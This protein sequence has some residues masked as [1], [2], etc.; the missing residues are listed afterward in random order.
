MKR[1]LPL[2]LVVLTVALFLG[3]VFI[4]SVHIPF[5]ETLH[6]LLGGAASK[7]SWAFIIVHSRIPAAVVALLTGAALAASGLMLQTAF[8]NPLAGPDILGINSGAGLGV[9]IVMLAFGGSLPVGGALLGAQV[10]VVAAA[11]IGALL[12][13]ALLLVFSSMTRSHV[14][15]LIIGLMLS[16][17]VSSAITLLNFFSTAEGVQS[18]TLWGMGSFGGVS[19]DRLPLFALLMAVGLA[20]AIS[21]I[22]PL[23]ALLLGIHY[24]E[25]LGINIRRTRALLLLSTGLLT[26]VSTAYCGPVTFIG[27]AVPHMARL[28]TGTAN[29]RQLM[30]ATLLCGSVV[31]LLCNLLTTL[32]A[33]GRLLPLGAITPLIGAPVILFVILKKK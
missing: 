11:F 6:V 8:N 13:T 27:L 14:M 3:N 28:L 26:A 20:M 33:G 19:L 16:Y 9:A 29:H 22:K 32:P 2:L 12:V 25:N 5:D 15:L 17:M 4:G 24:A 18:Y 10:T 30:P 7:E 21:L 1:L 23:N 31:A